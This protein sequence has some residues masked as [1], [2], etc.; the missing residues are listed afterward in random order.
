MNVTQ[1]I[2]E[3]QSRSEEIYDEQEWIHFLNAALD[4]LTPVA[5]MLRRVE[6][7]EQEPDSD[8]NII[9]TISE[10]A[11]LQQAHEIITVYYKSTNPS[12][13]Q[14]K[15]KRISLG[16]EYSSGWKLTIDE[17][18]IQNVKNSSQGDIIIYMYIKLPHVDD[19]D[20]IPLL[21]E[22]YHPLV[23]MYMCS[24]SQQKEEELEDKQDFYMEYQLG[25][26]Q[27]AMERIWQ[28][29]PHNRKYIEEARVHGAVG[30]SPPR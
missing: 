29:E 11:D 7:T 28:M 24:I 6:I 10:H 5:K 14:K 2:F 26:K 12:R 19:G 9:I 22:Q 3:S 15:V 30:Y 13:K 21:P 18:K 17:L 1:M 27:M 16:D 20:D 4:D 25:K 23:V 8:G